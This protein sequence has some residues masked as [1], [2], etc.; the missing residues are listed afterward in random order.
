MSNVSIKSTLKLSFTDHVICCPITP[1]KFQIF[2]TSSRTFQEYIDRTGWWIGS[3]GTKTMFYDWPNGCLEWVIIWMSPS[4]PKLGSNH[5]V[6]K[7][8]INRLM[9]IW[10]SDCNVGIKKKST[11]KNLKV[12]ESWEENFIDTWKTSC[13]HSCVRKSDYERKGRA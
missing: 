8:S 4:H 9:R 11:Y 10:Q 6:E 12:Q 3:N 7:L 2:T 1:S 13:S 5:N